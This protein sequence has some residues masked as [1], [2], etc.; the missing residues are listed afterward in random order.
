MVNEIETHRSKILCIDDDSGFV[1]ICRQFFDA[2][3]DLKVSVTAESGFEAAK[4]FLPDVIICDDRLPEWSGSEICTK[5]KES[6]ALSSVKFLLAYEE[7]KEK[8]GRWGKKDEDSQKEIDLDEVEAAARAGVD[9]YF[10]KPA[11]GVELVAKIKSL[12]KIKFLEDSLANTSASLASTEIKLEESRK[13]QGNQSQAIDN[14]REMLQNS[15]K[16]ISLMAEERER[17]NNKLEHLNRKLSGFVDSL[18]PLLSRFIEAKRQYHRGHSKNVAKI[19]TSIAQDL[20]LDSEEVRCIEIASLL[21]ELGKVTIPDVLAEKSPE[22]YT[23][24]EKDL[25]VQHPVKGAAMLEE[26]SEFRK[27]GEIIRSFHEYYNGE[28]Y[29]DGL[30]GERI[31]IGARII[32][33]ANIY[34]NLVYRKKGGSIQ[35]ALKAIEEERGGR[36]DPRLVFNLVAY[37]N[38]N[39]VSEADRATQMRVYELEPGMVL[40]YSLSTKGGTKLLPVNTVLTKI[41]IK[42]IVQYSKRDPIEETI[43]IKE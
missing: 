18:I 27:I 35:D 26:F 40:A 19:A 4:D 6:P 42:Q 11:I 43:F 30:K 31:P 2:D 21:H 29:P 16:Q 34:D 37:A 41:N 23:K 17:T 24:T 10:I 13:N 33:L 12:I 3:Y 36:Y 5:I 9:D 14:D 28:G 1:M 22:D 32:S 7:K 15:L 25:L 38:D 39:P 8:K 20:G